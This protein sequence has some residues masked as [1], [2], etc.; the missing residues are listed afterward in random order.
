MAARGKYWSRR[1]RADWPRLFERR[2]N[3]SERYTYKRIAFTVLDIHSLESQGVG[4]GV[5]RAAA[6]GTAGRGA[7]GGEG[8]KKMEMEEC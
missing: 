1:G 6:K 4:G 8:G 2:R 3:T 7:A 5:R